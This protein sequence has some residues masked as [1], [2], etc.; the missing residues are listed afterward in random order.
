[1]LGVSREGDDSGSSSANW[2]EVHR[3]RRGSMLGEHL[4]GRIESNAGQKLLR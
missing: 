1:M 2:T 3:R 4:A